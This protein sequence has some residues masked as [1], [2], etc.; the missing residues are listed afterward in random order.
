MRWGD[1]LC[2]FSAVS[3]AFHGLIVV[4]SRVRVS[5]V[6]L[7]VCMLLIPDLKDSTSVCNTPPHRA[8]MTHK[9]KAKHLE[10]EVSS[11]CWTLNTNFLSNSIPS[12]SLIEGSKSYDNRMHLTSSRPLWTWHQYSCQTNQW[13]HSSNYSDRLHRWKP[14]D[15]VCAS[16]LSL[17]PGTL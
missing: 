12:N 3:S 4:G 9:F 8:L 15:A 5:L 17:S 6:L 14:T 13:L 16:P 10:L 1:L 7:M 2:Y 11:A